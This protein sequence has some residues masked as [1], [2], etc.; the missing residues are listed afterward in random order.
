M[1]VT[2]TNAASIVAL[3]A[4]GGVFGTSEAYAAAPPASARDA[5]KAP[6][7]LPN[8]NAHDFGKVQRGA[9]AEHVFRIVNTSGV[10]LK[11]RSV[12]R[13]G[14]LCRRRRVRSRDQVCTSAQ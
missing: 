10:P 5:T 8:G 13:G 3:M 12:K 11:I 6:L 1:F 9:L 2:K 14:W 7:T 4:L